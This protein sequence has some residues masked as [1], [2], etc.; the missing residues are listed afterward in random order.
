MEGSR[1]SIHPYRC[2][3]NA[4]GNT[5]RTK[6]TYLNEKRHS[7][8]DNQYFLCGSRK[9]RSQRG[10]T[11]LN[12]LHF[13]HCFIR[14]F[15][16]K[17]GE[18][19]EHENGIQVDNCNVLRDMRSQLWSLATEANVTWCSSRQHPH[20]INAWSTSV[21]LSSIF[22]HATADSMQSKVTTLGHDYTSPES[23]DVVRTLEE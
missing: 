12:T 15:L 10:I 7:V 16:L 3:T 21:V 22:P 8:G 11:H 20:F 6:V 19:L 9:T 1:R 23:P 2:P 13:A 5:H 4:H 14:A 17:A 18:C